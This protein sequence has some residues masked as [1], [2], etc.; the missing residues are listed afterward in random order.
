MKI[1]TGEYEVMDSGT[2]IGILNEPIKFEFPKEMASLAIIINFVIEDLPK[3]AHLKFKPIDSKT[4]EIQFINFTSTLGTGNTE[5]LEIGYTG[6]RKIFIN[7]RVYA[8]K[9]LS[10]TLHY[11][12]YLGKEGSYVSK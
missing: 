10:N 12:F 2:V 9:G 11:T 3:E 4:L 6:N 5:M 7:Y 8:I 1:S